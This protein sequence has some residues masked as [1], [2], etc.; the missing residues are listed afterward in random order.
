MIALITGGIAPIRNANTMILA[1][2]LAIRK[3]L[4]GLGH[5][6]LVS[7]EPIPMFE[8]PRPIERIWS[9][10]DMDDFSYRVGYGSTTN[11]VAYQEPRNGAM[12]PWIAVYGGDEILLRIP[13]SACVIEYFIKGEEKKN[14]E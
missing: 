1:N 3:N 14:G 11:I 6:R 9:A 8:D 7:K 4:I 10:N 13:A 12:I 2:I 5:R